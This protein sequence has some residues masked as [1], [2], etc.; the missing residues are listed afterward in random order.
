MLFLGTEKYPNEND[1]SAFLSDNGGSSNAAT[2]PDCTKFYFDVVPD[3]LNETLDR[4]SQFFLAPLFTESAT[5]RE[6][7]AV[8][9]EHEKNLAM[10]VWRIRQVSKSLSDPKHAYSKFGT[11]N[12]ETLTQVNASEL[13][14]KLIEFH[15][16]WYSANLMCL[17]VLGKESLDELETNIV[18]LFSKIENKN[19]VKQKWEEMPYL[20]DQLATKISVVPVK[21]TRSLTVSFQ[22]KDLEQYYKSSPD[23]YISHLVGH[24]GKGSVLSYLKLKGWCSK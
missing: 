6:I 15:K 21:D 13:R 10:D 17:A 1:Y 9:S 12:K 23:H 4:F 24:E 7:N 14:K 3:K 18:E 19:K 11:G 5:E 22:S 20:R 2:Y 16:E 8:N